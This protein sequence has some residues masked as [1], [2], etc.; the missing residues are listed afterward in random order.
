MADIPDL[1]AKEMALLKQKIQRTAELKQQYLKQVHNPY[2]HASGE[3]G[4]VFDPAVARYQALR[5]GGYERFKPTWR[6][7]LGAF[8]VVIF[9]MLVYGY[10]LHKERSEKEHRFRTG[11]VSYRDRLFKFV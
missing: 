11:Q 6:N 1:S 9:P 3:G 7:G 8:G 5:A 10:F 4:F 2:R